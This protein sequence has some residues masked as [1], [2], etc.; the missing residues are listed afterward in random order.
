MACG[1]S[2]NTGSSAIE[3]EGVAAGGSDARGG[4]SIT[5]IST[6]TGVSE[7]SSRSI[8]KGTL[9]APQGAGSTVVPP[10]IKTE[11]EVTVRRWL[12]PMR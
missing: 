10:G 7:P 5:R 2:G 4:S 11:P 9:S 1:F 8:Q 6:L 3:G 12:I